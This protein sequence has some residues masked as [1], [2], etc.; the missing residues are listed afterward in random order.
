MES[1]LAY[2]RRRANQ[3]LA[4]AARSVTVNARNRRLQLAR[5]FLQRL[6]ASEAR[7]MAC[8]WNAMEIYQLRVYG[9]SVNDLVVPAGERRRNFS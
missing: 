2:Y 5:L 1:D 9:Q 7:A 8:K 3:E 6:E 4:A